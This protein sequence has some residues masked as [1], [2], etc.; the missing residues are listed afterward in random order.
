[1]VVIHELDSGQH[2]SDAYDTHSRDAV[3]LSSVF[4]AGSD[5]AFYDYS[6]S[7]DRYLEGV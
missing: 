2:R 3:A 7:T 6:S 4:F 1:V 5:D